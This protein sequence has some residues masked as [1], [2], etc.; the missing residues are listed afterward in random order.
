MKKFE[1][2]KTFTC[3]SRAAEEDIPFWLD[4]MELRW[5]DI[6]AAPGDKS[7]ARKF[8]VFDCN[9]EEATFIQTQI[10]Q[11]DHEAGYE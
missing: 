7:Y 3:H 6:Q 1:I 8:V 4:K 11:L 10:D 5:F 9:P 2:K